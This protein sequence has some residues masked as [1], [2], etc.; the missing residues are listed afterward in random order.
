MDDDYLTEEQ[1]AGCGERRR[2]TSRKPVIET[3]ADAEEKQAQ[4]EHDQNLRNPGMF[5]NSERRRWKDQA[6]SRAAFALRTWIET[7]E[8]ITGAD[9]GRG[10]GPSGFAFTD[11]GGG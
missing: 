7:A 11:D 8:R 3:R 1:A 9:Y 6:I 5:P 4:A 2:R 10:A